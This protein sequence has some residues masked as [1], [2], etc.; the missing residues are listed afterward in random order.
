MLFRQVRLLSK[1]REFFKAQHKQE[2]KTEISDVMFQIRL[3][4]LGD[5]FF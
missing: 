5:M 1:V 2:P 4:F 3:V